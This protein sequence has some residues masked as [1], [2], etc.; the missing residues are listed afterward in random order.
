M[1]NLIF[2]VC[3]FMEMSRKRSPE[4]T[5]SKS[6][7][8]SGRPHKPVEFGIRKKGRGESDETR[9]TEV[10]LLSRDRRGSGVTQQDNRDR[11][12]SKRDG[13]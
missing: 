2:T 12:T 5:R 3:V 11:R 13:R 9:P 10:R 1:M 4:K 8:Y 7:I 6:E